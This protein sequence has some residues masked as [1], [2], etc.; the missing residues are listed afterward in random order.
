[1][2][3]LDRGGLGE[4]EDRIPFDPSLVGADEHVALT[5]RALFT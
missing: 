4:R 3:T 2:T 1:M 5:M